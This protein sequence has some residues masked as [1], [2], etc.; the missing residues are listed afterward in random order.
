MGVI[1]SHLI[2]ETMFQGIHYYVDWLQQT[3]INSGFGKR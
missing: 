3:S 1:A 2:P